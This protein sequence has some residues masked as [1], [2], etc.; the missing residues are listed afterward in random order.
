MSLSRL[1]S[2]ALLLPA[3]LILATACKQTEAR[4]N[5]PVRYYVHPADAEDAAMSDYLK[6]HLQNR[7]R[8]N[9][10]ASAPG[11]GVVDVEVDVAKDLGGDYLVDYREDGIRLGAR[12]ERTMVWL[13]YRY[14][15]HVGQP[16]DYVTVDDLPPSLFPQ[17]DTLATF[18]F[19][20]RDLHM[21][22]NQNPD[23]TVLLGLHNLESD[24]GIWGHQLSVVLGNHMEDY[25]GYKSLDESLFAQVGGLVHDDQ[26]CFTSDRL[27]DLTVKY[28]IDQYGEGVDHPTRFTIGPND[29]R[30]VCQCAQC[31]AIGNKPA[32][33]SPAVVAFVTK[34][35]ARFPN[36]QFFIPV[37]GSVHSVPQ[38]RLPPNVGVFISAIGYPRAWNNQESLSSQLFFRQ[39]ESWKQYTDQVY[40]WDYIC[41][42]DDYLSPY[43]ILLVMQQRLQ[44]Y[45]R[46]GVK[47]LF[48]N[49]SG[50]FYS[51]LQEM[52]SFVLA[53][54]MVNPYADA[55][56]LMDAYF[57]DAMPHVGKFFAKM[58]QNM[59]LHTAREGNELPLYGGIDEALAFYLF[60]K[61]FREQYTLFLQLTDREMTHR[62][63]VIFDKTRQLVSFSFLEICRL[64][65]L[66][67]GGF[68]EK[69][70]G[71]WEVK[72]EVWQALEDLKTITPEDDIYILTDN[73]N[74]S[75]DHMDRI[76]ESGIY[77]ADYENE[78]QIWL[79]SGWWKKN[80]IL[81][82]PIT[83][84][85]DRGEWPTKRLTDGVSGISQNYH[86]GWYIMR[87]GNVVL[88]IPSATLTEPANIYL[89]ILNSPR[90]RMG[91]P[92]SIDVLVDG[93]TVTHM[94]PRSIS[95]YF[96]EGEKVVYQARIGAVAGAKVELAVTLSPQFTG[97][98]ID[99][100]FF[101]PI[102]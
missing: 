39:V 94:R 99:E 44:E 15:K 37:Y 52:Y 61:E 56:A 20:Y 53:E 23:M 26:F 92:E 35:A 3:C 19:E 102:Q 60:E 81:G 6:K 46:L 100:I 31:L 54:L 83:V 86:W 77:I 74:A 82:K 58:L 36:H 29:N 13:L 22:S 43:P 1:L 63:R 2:R 14:I 34:L 71:V 95:D 55:F 28:I 80:L 65:G 76:N 16:L 25:L 96:D 21:P 64:H 98:A 93:Q 17:G 70:D 48:L 27:F 33:S 78:C 32:D 88:E 72:E 90:H 97:I 101:N 11:D 67:K 38:K 30:V 87:H 9:M 66:S 73:E 69:R 68:A 59:E 79:E 47:G 50:Y 4:E 5:A 18:P 57:D 84:R 7:S 8:Y 12:D 10:L 45:V 62:E 42:F 91:P 85:G 41:N 40:V 24:W 51:S 75:P 49:G 89:G